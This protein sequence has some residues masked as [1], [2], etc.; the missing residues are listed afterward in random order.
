MFNLFF[1]FYKYGRNF[2]NKNVESR[3]CT[4]SHCSLTKYTKIKLHHKIK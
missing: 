2:N 1:T 3:T 4:K